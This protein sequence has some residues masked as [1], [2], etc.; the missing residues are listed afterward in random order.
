MPEWLLFLLL[1]AG[2]AGAAIGLKKLQPPPEVKS[3]AP[4]LNLVTSFEGIVVAGKMT[5][6]PGQVSCVAYGVVFGRMEGEEHDEFVQLHRGGWTEGFEIR[7]KDGH[8]ISVPKGPIY[9]DGEWGDTDGRAEV[10]SYLAAAEVSS[11]AV[12]AVLTSKA[13]ILESRVEMNA[14][15][16]VHATRFEEL[17]VEAQEGD[18]YRHGLRKHVARG[19]ILVRSSAS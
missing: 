13:V 10:S 11:D 4:K 14:S 8:I 3:A 12:H 17:F 18:A 19:D 15:V 9:V 5:V 1:A 2:V 6:S 16:T 7:T